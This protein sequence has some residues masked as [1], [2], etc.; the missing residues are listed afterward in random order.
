MPTVVPP[1]RIDDIALLFAD[2][3][4]DHAFI[5][6]IF[7]RDCP[8][9]RAWVDTLPAPGL[10]VASHRLGVAAL[11]GTADPELL[12]RLLAMAL[13]AD[14]G[15]S[16][17]RFLI[18]PSAEW[19]S[20]FKELFGHQWASTERVA[21]RVPVAMH[22]AAPSLPD[23][24][25]LQPID[26]KLAGRLAAEIEPDFAAY[27]PEV[28]DFLR[29]GAGFA[30]LAGTQVASIA[31]AAL[32]IGRYLQKKSCESCLRIFYAIIIIFSYLQRL[33]N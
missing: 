12:T 26:R 13:N 4:Y 14:E 30:V 10:A 31:F 11:A 1:N 27:W 20:V 28:D 29:R 5:E 15:W 21:Y 17:L 23:G 22:Y 25:T 19:V 24:Y 7:D 3:P 6:A 8:S 33:Y 2:Y 32:P 18:I 16:A 9:Y